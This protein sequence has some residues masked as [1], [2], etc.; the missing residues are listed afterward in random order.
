[1]ESLFFLLASGAIGY[2][3]QKLERIDSRINA[4]EDSILLLNHNTEKRHDHH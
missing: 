1:M 3:I 4:V 2:V